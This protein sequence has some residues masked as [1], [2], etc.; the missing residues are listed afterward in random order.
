M[1]VGGAVATHSV[2]HGSWTS[3]PSSA[4][5][6]RPPPISHLLPRMIHQ[7]LPYSNLSL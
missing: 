1:V 3:A 2:D 5:V 7:V 4:A 6:G